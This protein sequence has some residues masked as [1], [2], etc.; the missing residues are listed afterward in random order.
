MWSNGVCDPVVGRHYCRVFP[1][2]TWCG[3][4]AGLLEEQAVHRHTAEQPEEHQAS[5]GRQRRR[6]AF[7]GTALVQRSAML[8]RDEDA[9]PLEEL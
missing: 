4:A 1:G 2:N 9:E 3:T 6:E 8:A 7:L 5:S